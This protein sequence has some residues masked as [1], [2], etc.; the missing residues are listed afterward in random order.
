MNL[1]TVHDGFTLADTV[2]YNTK[3]NEANGED[4]RDGTDDNRS[5]NCGVEEFADDPTVL[6]LR[7]R[8][9]RN[10][11]A[12]LMLSEGAPLLLGGDEFGRSQGGNN[13][14]YCHDDE[15]TW[16][17]WNAAAKNTGLVDFTAR[18]CRLREQHPVFRRRQFFQGTPAPESTRD[19]LDWYRPDGIPMASQDWNESFARAVMMALRSDTGDPARPD[20]PFIL[21]LNS[22]WEPIDFTLPDPLRDLGW[23]IEIDTEHPDAAGRAVDP[24]SP[25]TLTGRSLMLL[26]STQPAS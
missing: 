10:L 4:N 22:W 21:M 25:V 3:H 2:S 5:W 6:G 26:H 24:I 18:L 23:Q 19:D 12:T 9:Q 13:N 17:D 16:F 14:A 1:I 8:Q 7:A 15:V 11:I 20:D